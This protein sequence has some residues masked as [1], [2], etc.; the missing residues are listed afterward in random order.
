[1][2]KERRK[3]V[4]LNVWKPIT[5]TIG[6]RIHYGL[7]VNE[8]KGGMFIDTAAKLSVGDTIEMTYIGLSSI[9]VNRKGKIVRIES[10]GIAVQFDNPDHA[11]G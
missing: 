5:F 4:R 7:I 2:I 6:G 8:S 11:G 3:H 9:R 10:N 1:M